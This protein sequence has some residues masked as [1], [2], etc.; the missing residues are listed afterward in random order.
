MNKKIAIIT[1]GSSGIG[2]AIC[3]TLSDN[4]YH[5]YAACRN[6]ST[7]SKN[8]FFTYLKMDVQSEVSVK[9]AV[10]KVIEKE[11]RIDVLVNCAGLGINGPIEETPIDMVQKVFDTNFFGLVRTT[12]EV[13]PHMR[14]T[15]SGFVINISSIAGEFGLPMRGYYSASKAAV[16]MLTEALR[17]EVRQFGIKV[18]AVQPGDFSTNISKNRPTA[19]ISNESSY[20]S[21]FKNINS[22]VN[23]EVGAARDPSE[24]ANAVFKILQGK[25]PKVK[26]KVGP[27]LQKLSGIIKGIVPGR[28][29][30]RMIMNHYK[31]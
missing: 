12:Q 27:L 11:S 2:E 14:K 17:M 1:G 5:V 16:E 20:L 15:A 10:A 24:V 4:G 29:F 3:N 23:V 19:T 28:T 6:P 18:C 31:L 8:E 26:Y 21:M 25:N 7:E 22:Q 30:E 9:D 13:L